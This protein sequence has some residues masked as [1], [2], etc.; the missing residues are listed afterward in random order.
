MEW[1]I[2][3]FDQVMNKKSNINTI[4][5]TNR[6]ELLFGYNPN[7]SSKLVSN[8]TPVVMVNLKAGNR[9]H[10]IHTY[11]LTWL[12]NIGLQKSQYIYKYNTI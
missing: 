8:P 10:N 2:N 12:F 9:S 11:R 4:N 3:R 7:L 6:E 1:D 5:Y